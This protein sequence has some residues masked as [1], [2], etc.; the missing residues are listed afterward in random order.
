MLTTSLMKTGA[1]NQA[2]MAH[3]QAE[4]LKGLSMLRAVVVP[5]GQVIY[6]FY[7]SQRAVT[8]RRAQKANGGS[9]SSTSR[10]SSTS[11]FVTDIR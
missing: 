6:R 2:Q 1:I 5:A 4:A 7:D 9:S 11:A 3:G 10:L 8:P